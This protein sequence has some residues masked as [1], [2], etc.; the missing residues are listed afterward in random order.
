MRA[1]SIQ[2]YNFRMSDVEFESDA[3]YKGKKTGSVLYSRFEPSSVPPKIVQFLIAKKI[4]KT[5]TQAS[6]I[7][8]LIV[9]MLVAA[10][11]YIFIRS[12]SAAAPVSTDA[13]M[14]VLFHR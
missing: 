8:V 11:V 4:V 2:W 13:V 7:L 10:S 5:E 12:S 6:L 3:M 14:K 9:L 1:L